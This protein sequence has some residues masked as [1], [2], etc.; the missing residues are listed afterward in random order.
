MGTGGGHFGFRKSIASHG[1]TRQLPLARETAWFRKQL[2]QF[3]DGSAVRH[4]EDFAGQAI[5][6]TQLAKVE[7]EVQYGGRQIFG[8]IGASGGMSGESV[9]FTNYLSH[10]E[11]TA[12]YKE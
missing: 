3:L 5:D 7:E 6:Q 12:G 1:Q 10:V 9:G 11:T 2:K 8:A 4:G